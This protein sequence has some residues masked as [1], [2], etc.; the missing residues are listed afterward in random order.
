MMFGKCALSI[1]VVLGMSLEGAKATRSLEVCPSIKGIPTNCRR[2]LRGLEVDRSIS[3]ADLSDLGCD[4]DNED[5]ELSV[6][7]K[8]TNVHMYMIAKPASSDSTCPELGFHRVPPAAKQMIK[9]DDTLSAEFDEDDLYSFGT[10][11]L[12]DVI[13]AFDAA[14]P[15]SS[16]SNENYDVVTNNCASLV[17]QM[18]CPLD[19]EVTED[20]I[21]WG[22]ERFMSTPDRIDFLRNLLENQTTNLD[23]LIVGNGNGGGA[24][25]FVQ[26][27]TAM[28]GSLS[29]DLLMYLLVKFAGSESCQETTST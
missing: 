18:M 8:G 23:S 10:F 26:D 25:G 27:S 15:S 22:A 3:K 28:V 21:S 14:G 5:V 7:L 29:D 11:K 4:I 20:L 24:I 6:G 12:A 1:L 17:R 19:V 16:S 13:G 9:V 2:G